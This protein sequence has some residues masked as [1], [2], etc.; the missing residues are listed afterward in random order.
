MDWKTAVKLPWNIILLFGGGFAL[1]SGFMESGLSIWFG[2]QLIWVDSLHPIFIIL[3]IS[4]M[5][6]FLTELTS[7]TATTEML[8]PILAGLAISLKVNPLLFMVP[9]TLSASLAFMLPVATPPNAIIFG[10]N[11]IKIRDMARIGLFLN[12]IGAVV[13]CLATYFL[14]KL[15]LGIEITGL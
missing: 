15:F 12:I 9:A 11:R 13:V 8:L 7:N 5:V 4:L 1:A 3:A 10:T 2:E 6:T 14:G